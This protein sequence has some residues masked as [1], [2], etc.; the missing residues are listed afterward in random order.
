MS[1]KAPRVSAKQMIAV[2]ERVGFI[3]IRQNGSHKIYKSNAGK[4][5]TIPFH[6]EKILHPKVLKSICEDVGIE[7]EKL[8]ELL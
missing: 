2:L 1:E 8:R 6:G 4:R 7:I 5:V 3:F